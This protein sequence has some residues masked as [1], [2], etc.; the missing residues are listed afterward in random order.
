MTD[1]SKLIE[2]ARTWCAT[3]QA[4]WN[5]DGEPAHSWN[6]VHGLEDDAREFVIALAAA[7]LPDDDHANGC[8]YNDEGVCITCGDVGDGE[9]NWWEVVPVGSMLT[10]KNTGRGWARFTAPDGRT[11]RVDLFTD[12]AR[13]VTG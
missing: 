2:E 13:Q 11:F 7:E 12:E 10:Y 1:L 5:P 6:E 8:N 4:A 9:G 3:W